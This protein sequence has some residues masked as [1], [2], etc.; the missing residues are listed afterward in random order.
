MTVVK[1]AVASFSEEE[2]HAELKVN[3][4]HY[5]RIATTAEGLPDC[6]HGSPEVLS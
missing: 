4:P 5:A 2:T 1:E 3:L 6:G